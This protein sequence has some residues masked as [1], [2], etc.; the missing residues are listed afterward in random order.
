[1]SHC[2]LSEH[3]L[4]K[5][6]MEYQVAAHCDALDPER[7]V[8]NVINEMRRKT[9]GRAIIVHPAIHRRKG[10]TSIPFRSSFLD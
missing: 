6:D 4:D 10:S 8:W 2:V 5:G 7:A 9:R 3:P 1:M